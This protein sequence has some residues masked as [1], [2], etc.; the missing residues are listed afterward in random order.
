MQCYVYSNGEIPIRHQ[1]WLSLESSLLLQSSGWEKKILPSFTGY[2]WQR[3]PGRW[4]EKGVDSRMITYT[5]TV[6][7]TSVYITKQGSG[8]H[9][10]LFY[11]PIIQVNPLPH[12]LG[13]KT[14]RNKWGFLLKKH[15]QDGA[16]QPVMLMGLLWRMLIRSHFLTCQVADSTSLVSLHS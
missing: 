4:G 3:R 14:Q 13:S 11:R 8:E 6:A 2:I 1:W 5:R 10:Q 12:L 16:A 9:E 7:A 15:T